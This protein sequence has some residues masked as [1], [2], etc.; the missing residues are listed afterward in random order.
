MPPSVLAMTRGRGIGAVQQHGEVKFL[1]DLRSGGDQQRLHHAAFGAGLLGDE[2]IA[3][4]FF[5]KANRFVHGRCDFHA[6]L[7]A[8]LESS[9]A[10]SPAWICDLTTTRELPAATSLSASGRTSASDLAGNSRGDND[11]VFGEQLLGLVFV[12]IHVNKSGRH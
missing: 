12:D 3:K 11:A 8:G 6:A 2:H 4:H 7:K 1:C 9:L 10:A 5:G